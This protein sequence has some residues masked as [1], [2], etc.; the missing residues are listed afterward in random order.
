MSYQR[1]NDTSRRLGAAVV[2]AALP[3]DGS[4]V[5]V[6]YLAGWLDASE[7][8]IGEYLGALIAVG[9]VRRS[10]GGMYARIESAA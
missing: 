1:S 9:A 5:P 6:A 3:V 8:T 2:L 4:E 10:R 7:T